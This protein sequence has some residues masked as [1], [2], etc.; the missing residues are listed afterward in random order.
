MQVFAKSSDLAAHMRVHTCEKPY[1]VR[2][3][4]EFFIDNLLVRNHLIIV[5]IRW[6]GL[7][8]WE[9]DFPFAGSL[10]STFLISTFLISTFL[11]RS[12]RVT[13]PWGA[14][15]SQRRWARNPES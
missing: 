14:S 10:I 3:E 8:P 11:V 1:K 12:K 5:M 2:R 7:A 4:R 13:L 9:I 6:T 15:A